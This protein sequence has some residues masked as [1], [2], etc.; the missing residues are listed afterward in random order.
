MQQVAYRRLAALEAS[1]QIGEAVAN[2]E[3][4]APHRQHDADA[5]VPRHGE[6]EQ[7]RDIGSGLRRGPEL[8]ELIDDEEDLA[9]AVWVL[10]R[11]GQDGVAD[12]VG[13]TSAH[14]IGEIARLAWPRAG[15]F[16]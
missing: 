3:I 1:T 11:A 8:L 16:R 14:E 15:V 13:L 9:R 6:A 10:W 2:V 5:V 7:R 12:P 4:I